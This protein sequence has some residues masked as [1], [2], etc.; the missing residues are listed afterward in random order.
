MQIINDF[1]ASRNWS[2]IIDG[3]IQWGTIATLS[4]LC[5]IFRRNI[6]TTLRAIRN[7]LRRALNR[8]RRLNPG[9]MLPAHTL[10]THRLR[11]RL[12]QIE[13]QL[14]T[15]QGKATQQDTELEKSLNTLLQWAAHRQRFTEH[16]LMSSMPWQTAYTN[17]IFG[18][19]LERNLIDAAG[20]PISGLPTRYYITT[21]GC[22]CIFRAGLLRPGN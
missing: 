3:I 13:K 4:T 22:E 19:A 7:K 18:L 6:A 8:I 9:Q 11:R 15:L 5:I 17:F 14:A 20:I 21:G 2:T 1:L 16:E 10:A 12:Q